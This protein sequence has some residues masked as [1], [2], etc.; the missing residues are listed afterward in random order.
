MR[1]AEIEGNR[2]RFVL[3]PE[4]AEIYPTMP[5]NA[6]DITSEADVSE[7]Y[8]YENGA[9]RPPT[10]D[11]VNAVPLAMF[12]AER[13]RRFSEAAW[14]RERH[15]DRVDMGIDDE[16]NWD[17]WLNYWQTLRDMPDTEGFNPSEP[18]WPEKPE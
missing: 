12:Q 11:E 14:V 4:L 15:A 17:A 9:F 18:A 6:V 10:T 7:G 1:Y 2:V 5:P 13:T 16:E 3:P 8:I